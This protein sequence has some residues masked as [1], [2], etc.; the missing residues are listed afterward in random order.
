MQGLPQKFPTNS[1]F[2]LLGWYMLQMAKALLS[3]L[4][5]VPGQAG[6][7]TAARPTI[8]SNVNIT[9]LKFVGNMHDTPLQ[10]YLRMQSATSCL[11]PYSCQHAPCFNMVHNARW[12]CAPP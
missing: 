2:L 8:K 7:I 3:K 10:L 4:Y 6:L 11:P 12:L 9:Y 5:G 1:C